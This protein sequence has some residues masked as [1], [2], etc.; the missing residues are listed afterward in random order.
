MLA[1]VDRPC[2][3]A[4]TMVLKSSSSRT[5][6][7]ASRATSVPDLPMATPIAPPAER[8]RR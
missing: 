3:T 4:A 1:K 2:S 5:R 6:S 8:G 7:A